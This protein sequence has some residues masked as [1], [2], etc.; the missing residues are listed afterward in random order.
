M[1][2]K[3]DNQTEEKA[4]ID[5]RE[6]PVMVRSKFCH[7]DSLSEEDLVRRHEDMAEM[8]GY[9]VVNGIERIVRMLIMTK[10]NYPVAFARPIFV[11]RGK[12]FTPYAVQMRCVRDDMFS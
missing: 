8:G 6:V 12:L 10:R 5:L 11:N 4:R 7:L 3:L 2:R 9:F 1:V